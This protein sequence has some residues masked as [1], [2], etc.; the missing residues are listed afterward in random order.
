MSLFIEFAGM[1]AGMLTEQMKK[2]RLPWWK[3]FLIPA[4]IFFSLFSLYVIF[5]PSDRG[6][7]AGF[8]MAF[9]FGITTGGVFLL[10]FFLRD[11]FGKSR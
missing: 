9:I 11:R 8:A 1:A 6:L 5:F 4:A 2:S 10:V 7:L 3:I